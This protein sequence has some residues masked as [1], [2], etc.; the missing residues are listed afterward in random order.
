[1][2]IAHAGIYPHAAIALPEVG[3]EEAAKVAATYAA[4]RELAR[5]AKDSQADV[6]VLI[7][8]H[9][10]LFRDAVAMLDIDPLMGTLAQFGVSGIT[11][12]YQND[13]SLL[14]AV[15]LEADRAGIRTAVI[16]KRSAA[17]Y[18]V[19]AELDH[20]ATV[21]LYFFRQFDINLPLLHLTFG[22]LP[23]RRLFEFGRACRRALERQKKRAAVICSSD[24]S[25]RLIPGAPTGYSPAGRKFDEKLASLLEQY[26]VEGVINIDSDLL[27][28]AGECGYRSIL[29]CLGMLDG[30]TVVP[31]I[32]SYEGPFGVGYLTADL[33]PAGNKRKP[34]EHVQLAKKALES[35]V[36]QGERIKSPQDSELNKTKAGA[37]VT[38]KMDGRL[39]GCIGTIEPLRE[40]LAREIIENAIS[41]GTADP[42]FSPVTAG[43]LPH[44]SY[45]VD[46][47]LTPEK[48]SGKKEL[49]PKRYGVIVESGRRR[50][51]LLPDLE[52]VNT[53]EEQLAI[54]LQKAGISPGEPYRLYRFLV[55]RYK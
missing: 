34:S 33:T 41:A 9:G 16:D 47:L 28:E 54:A 6:I 40:S 3:K 23:P 29:I 20:G 10:P 35:Y 24:L 15:E 25:H 53:A 8:P 49:D 38:L 37:F 18:R 13:R 12:S 27:E 5:R 11:Y 21:P 26:D 55:R 45:S 30:D 31:E 32:L 1:M 2:T 19:A 39:R 42:R 4:M 52:G 51:L 44:L 43:E 48:I 17:A 36:L 14:E 22:L 7:T 50:G 46:V